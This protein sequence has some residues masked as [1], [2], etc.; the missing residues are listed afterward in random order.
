MQRFIL[1]TV[2]N[3][4][5][6]NQTASFNLHE[7]SMELSINLKFFIIESVHYKRSVVLSIVVQLSFYFSI[8]DHGYGSDRSYFD[9]HWNIFC[10]TTSDELQVYQE[11]ETRF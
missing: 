6:D 1:K 5:A 2:L 3:F 9:Y 8:F 10:E 11:L 4:S 7:I